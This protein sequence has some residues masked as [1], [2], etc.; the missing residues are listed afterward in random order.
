MKMTLTRE[1]YAKTGA[2]EIKDDQSSAIVYAYEEHGKFYLQGFSGRKA[3]PDFHFWY[4][5]EAERTQKQERFFA[6]H[7]A[8]EQAKATRAAERK[9]PHT[10]KVGNILVASWGYSMTLVDFYEVVAVTAHGA[11]LEMVG[12][13]V[14]DGD[15]G[16]SGRVIANP[17][18]RTGKMTKVRVPA[19]NSPKVGNTW[20]R[21]WDGS[22]QYFNRVD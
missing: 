2:T 9:A 5:N 13:T 4:R 6:G 20:A 18:Q 11:T 19:D 17:E 14:V 3:K 22:S 8:A 10:L 7:R 16:Y 1:F 12:S 15:A 21:P